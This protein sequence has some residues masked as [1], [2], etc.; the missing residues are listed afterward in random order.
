VLQLAALLR[1]QHLVLHVPEE[2][3]LGVARHEAPSPKLGV[4]PVLL[5]Q[6]HDQS[7]CRV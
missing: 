5:V 2:Q 3:L 4:P 6:E 7:L 1:W